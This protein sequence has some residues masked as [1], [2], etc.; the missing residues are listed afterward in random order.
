M[1]VSF[2]E[3]ADTVRKTA[4]DRGYVANKDWAKANRDF[5]VK[6]VKIMDNPLNLLD[7][8]EVLKAV[9]ASAS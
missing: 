1:L 9:K 6:F 2:Q 7:P 3:S 5:M 4:K 8:E